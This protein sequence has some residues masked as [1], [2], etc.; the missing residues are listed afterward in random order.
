VT[1]AQEEAISLVHIYEGRERCKVRT[2][3]H[4]ALV[5]TDTGLLYRINRD[6]DVK[7][8]SDRSWD[9]AELTERIEAPETFAPDDL[10]DPFDVPSLEIPGAVS[11]F[12]SDR[13]Y[14]LAEERQRVRDDIDFYRREEAA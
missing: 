6:G 8:D 7:K 10:N 1:S 14:E 9:L 4:E 11:D 2:E 13:A 12:H 3:G 5:E